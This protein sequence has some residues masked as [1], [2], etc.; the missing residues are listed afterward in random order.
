MNRKLF[1]K[2]HL[3]L[4]VPFGLI[5]MLICFTGAMLVFEDEVEKS[6]RHDFYYV[7]SNGR[8]PLPLGKIAEKVQDALPDSVKVTGIVVSSNPDL[9]YQVNLSKPR[10]ASMVVDQYTGEIRGRDQRMPFFST[11]FGLHRWL[12]NPPSGG[13]GIAW[14]K[15]IVGVSTLLF[16]VVLITGVVIWWPRT[17]KALK[18]S[19]KVSVSHGWRRFWY[20]LH[21]A[22]GMYALVFLLAMALTGLTWSFGWYRT[23]FYKVFGV[24]MQQ[25]GPGGAHGAGEK[26]AQNAEG[27]NGKKPRG[28]KPEGRPEG[29]ANA[30]T[31]ASPKAAQAEG[32]SDK[33]PRGEKPEGKPES[34]VD[35]TTGASPRAELFRSF[36]QWQTV[37]EKVKAENPDYSKITVSD[38]SATGSLGSLGNGRASDR[39]KFDSKT[40]EITEAS[41]YKDADKQGK[42]RGWIFSVH[43]GSWGGWFT[44]ILTFLAALLGAS[45]PLTGYYLWIKRLYSKPKR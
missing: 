4:S 28:E 45:L 2:L 43:T 1:R 20:G 16:V 24:E 34:N 7:E 6:A 10:R 19:L 11:M 5:I 35:A 17:K 37:Y 39:Y 27:R 22:G 12:L 42:I 41:L 23:G 13:D 30:D 33:K 44:R 32:R 36:L 29:N 21:V 14:G 31:G 15:M 18:N 38:G 8:T 9:A 26:S 25:Q 40:G 3:W